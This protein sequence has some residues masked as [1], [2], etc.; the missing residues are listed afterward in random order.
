MEIDVLG[1]LKLP[2][3]YV[4]QAEKKFSARHCLSKFCNL[5]C[6]Q[7]PSP[8]ASTISMLN[9]DTT[10]LIERLA[11]VQQDKWLLEEKVHSI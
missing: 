3:H 2:R 9:D 10:D 5:I 4:V 1:W 7:P 6:F 11:D 8:T